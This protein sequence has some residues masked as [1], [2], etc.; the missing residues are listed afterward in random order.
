M[1]VFVALAAVIIHLWLP[2]LII[3]SVVA[4]AGWLA[5]AAVRRP[6]GALSERPGPGNGRIRVRAGGPARRSG[7]QVSSTSGEFFNDARDVWPMPSE[8]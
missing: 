7:G 3:L 8:G 4:V 6:K 2:L 5:W 1:N